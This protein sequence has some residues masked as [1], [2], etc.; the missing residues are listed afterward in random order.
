VRP[1]YLFLPRCLTWDI[2]QLVKAS[3]CCGVEV[4]WW[5]PGD[6]WTPPEDCTLENAAVYGALRNG[7]LVAAYLGGSLLEPPAG[8]LPGLAARYR[9]RDVA[10]TTLAAA[11]RNRMPAFVKLAEG[12]ELRSGV[13]ARGSDIAPNGLPPDL[14]TL[15]GEVVTWESEFR[16]FVVDREVRASSPYLLPAP[17]R[18]RRR[19]G[20]ALEF[21]ERLLADPE[22]ELPGAVALDVGVIRNRGWSVVEA[23]PVVAS[24]L[25]D[26]DPRSVLDALPHGWT[27]TRR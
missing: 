27:S 23:N 9:N 20:E 2:A 21:A 10:L 26:C 5:T 8:F 7:R 6:A 18:H 11:R 13:Y 12:K 1:R 3:F 25:F 4:V 16:L 22:V 14:P 15:V 17:E 24:G 19:A